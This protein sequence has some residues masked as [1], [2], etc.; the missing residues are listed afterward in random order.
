MQ[1]IAPPLYL[2]SR[3][4]WG[5]LYTIPPHGTT[6]GAATTAATAAID[7]T[8][9]A[10]AA[11][12]AAAASRRLVCNLGWVLRELE[13]GQYEGGGEGEEGAGWGQEGGGQGDGE[14]M[15]RGERRNDTRIRG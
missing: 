9:A 1:V 15:A 11:A 6:A 12:A 4:K 3:K 7:A 10:T 8:A 5:F 13:G 14:G 2:C